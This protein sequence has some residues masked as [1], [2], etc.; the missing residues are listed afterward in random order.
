MFPGHSVAN[1]SQAEEAVQHGA[2]FI[3]HLFNAML[4]VSPQRHLPCSRAALGFLSRS[5]WLCVRPSWFCTMLCNEVLALNL[6]LRIPAAG[7]ETFKTVAD[8]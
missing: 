1:L 5:P 4:P 7:S 8:P 3:T 2:T 6:W